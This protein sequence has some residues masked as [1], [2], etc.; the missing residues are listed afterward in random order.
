MWGIIILSWIYR[1][2]ISSLNYRA[3]ILELFNLGQAYLRF[4]CLKKLGIQL[5]VLSLFVKKKNILLLLL[6]LKKNNNNDFVK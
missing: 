5:R 3:F 2:R 6:L 4:I 1:Q